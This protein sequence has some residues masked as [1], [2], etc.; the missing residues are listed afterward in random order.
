MTF[1]EAL[2]ELRAK[3]PTAD[4]S[5]SV[6]RGSGFDRAARVAFKK[7][8]GFTFVGR[9]ADGTEVVVYF[10]DTAGVLACTEVESFA[11]DEA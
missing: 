6:Q 2:A 10:N 8:K 7:E 5:P 9:D 3:H 4:L 11:D 1:A